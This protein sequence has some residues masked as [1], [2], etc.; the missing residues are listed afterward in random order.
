MES[1]CQGKRVC[2]VAGQPRKDME[3]GTPKRKTK[4]RGLSSPERRGLGGGLHVGFYF[5]AGN[6]ALLAANLLFE[7]LCVLPKVRVV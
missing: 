1:E 6:T 4:G 7:M 2:R 5:S 3:G